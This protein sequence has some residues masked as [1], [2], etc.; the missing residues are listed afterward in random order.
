MSSTTRESVTTTLETLAAWRSN[1][2][3]ILIGNDLQLAPPAFT[4]AEENL[5]FKTMAMSA[6][7]RFS[8]LHMRA[9]LLNEQMR[10]PA[11]IMQSSNDVVWD[12]RLRDRKGTALSENVQGRALKKASAKCIPQSS[13]SPPTQRSQ[14]VT[15][16]ARGQIS[17][18][19][20]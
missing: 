7:A 9:F 13:R 2:T 18:Q 14:R 19:R 6:F 11:R 1:E 3:L 4:G 5:S 20:V 16:G 17:L 8:D 15:V 10:V 12:G